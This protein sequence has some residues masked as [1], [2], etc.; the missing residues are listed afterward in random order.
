MADLTSGP[1]RFACGECGFGRSKSCDLSSVQ[2]H[3]RRS[4]RCNSTTIYQV[5]ETS[6]TL[7]ILT[8]RIRRWSTDPSLQPTWLEQR[9]F[10]PIVNDTIIFP[11][12]A[13]T[14]TPPEEFFD[15]WGDG[16]GIALTKSTDR[17]ALKRRDDKWWRERVNHYGVKQ[18]KEE[19]DPETLDE[20]KQTMVLHYV[21]SAMDNVDPLLRRL[22]RDVNEVYQNISALLL[23]LI[24]VNMIME[25]NGEDMFNA[26]MRE[27][28]QGMIR[29]DLRCARVA[30][31]LDV[32]P[33]AQKET[34]RAMMDVMILDGWS[35]ST[36]G[37]T[38]RNA[39]AIIDKVKI[40]SDLLMRLG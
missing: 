7:A 20:I 35:T 38:D 12:A 4:F 9:T 13:D 3:I 1:A 11:L 21:Q 32:L 14:A 10:R 39:D 36:E 29:N 25:S 27:F 23:S 34:I 31:F 15:F 37:L 5:E 24:D 2:N 6:T 33:E 26:C 8:I 18:K 28:L 22:L 30:M 16:N 19:A 40:A 17:P